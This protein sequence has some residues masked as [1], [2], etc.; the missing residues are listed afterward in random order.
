MGS[1]ASGLAAE[2]PG[3][4]LR[5]PASGL[6]FS[7]NQLRALNCYVDNLWEEDQKGE[8]AE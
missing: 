1:G 7:I 2:T 4:D 8:M 5:L 6:K 3:G